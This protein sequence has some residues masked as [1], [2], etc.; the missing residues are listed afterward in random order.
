MKAVSNILALLLFALS[1]V[2]IP[3]AHKLELASDSDCSCCCGAKQSEEETEG[4][5]SEHCPICQLATSPIDTPVPFT[6]GLVCQTLADKPWSAVRVLISK[7]SHLLP[8][9]CG[10]PA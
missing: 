7:P 4:H 2:I 1:L 9:S 8:Y 5:D 3:A 10:P 6:L